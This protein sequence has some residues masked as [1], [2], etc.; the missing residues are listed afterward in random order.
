MVRINIR[1]KFSK[2]SDMQF[3][4]EIYKVVEIKGSNITLDNGLVK[5]RDMLLNVTNNL[6]ESQSRIIID[7]AYK[8]GEIDRKILAEGISKDTIIKSKKLIKKTL[9]IDGI[10]ASNIINSKRTT[11]NNLVTF[12]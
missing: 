11:R 4:S 12:K 3:S 10:D 2:G 8:T 6:P 9:K 1:D 5:K 7:D